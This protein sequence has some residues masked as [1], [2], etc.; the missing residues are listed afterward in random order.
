MKLTWL[1]ILTL[2]ILAVTAC[3]TQPS[4]AP[5]QAVPS[6]TAAVPATAPAAPSPSTS[7]PPQASPA[8]TTLGQLSQQGATVFSTNCA[9]CHGNNGEGKIGPAVIGPSAS[10]AKYNTA[11]G[12]LSFV[13]LTMPR[14]APGS[15]SH[16]DYLNTVA[17]LLVQNNEAPANTPFNESQL[18]NIPLK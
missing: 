8:G 17:Y 6:T 14:N 15:L 3:A 5:T 13:A 18:G 2:I 11:Q 7:L 4:A 10:L 1:I 9:A 16:Q 12:L